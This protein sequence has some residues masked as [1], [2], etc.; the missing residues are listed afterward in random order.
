MRGGRLSHRLNPAARWTNRQKMMTAKTTVPCLLLP[1]APDRL[2]SVSQQMVKSCGAWLR[3]PRQPKSCGSSQGGLSQWWR[4]RNQEGG[5][6]VE[7]ALEVE[8][9]QKRQQWR[10]PLLGLLMNQTKTIHHR[11]LTAKLKELLPNPLRTRT[12][13]RVCLCTHSLSEVILHIPHHIFLLTC[14]C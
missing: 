4:R 3:T 2:A 7:A 14:L 6:A 5:G 8:V 13:P 11:A 1:P 12:L 10:T 9:L